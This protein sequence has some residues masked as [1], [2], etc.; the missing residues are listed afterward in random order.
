MD[1]AKFYASLRARGSGVFGTSLSQS[2]VNGMNSLLDEAINRAV[3][4]RHFAYMLATAYLETA[5]TMQPISEYGKRAYFDKYDAGT[6]LGK[7][8]GNVIKGDGYTFRGRGYVQLTGRANYARAANKLKVDFVSM[9]DRVMEPKLAAAIMFVGMAEGWFTGKKLTD[10]ILGTKADYVGARRI[11]N[12]TDK[13]KMIADYAVAFEKALVAAGY[14]AQPVVPPA[15]R[16]PVHVSPDGPLSGP[17]P[18][19]PGAEAGSAPASGGPLK[20]AV[21]AFL[22]GLIGLGSWLAGL[23]CDVLGIFCQ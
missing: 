4:L 18:D 10:Y 21:G 23:P 19:T 2:Q 7:A 11:I 17:V 16:V 6:K 3:P 9:P 14:V 22:A 8:L 5:H 1:R 12:G 13:A 15:L 20:L